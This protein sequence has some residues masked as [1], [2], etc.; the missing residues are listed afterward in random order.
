MSVFDGR[1]CHFNLL[2]ELALVS[3]YRIEPIDHV[4]LVCMC[5][6]VA[7][8]AEGIHGSERFFAASL[9][10]AIHALRLIDNEDRLRGPNQI[11]RLFAARLFAVL[12]EIVDVPFV[13]S[14]DCHHHDLNLRTGGKVPHLTELGRVV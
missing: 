6:R 10:T 8:C 3:I 14:A 4:V 2:D 13:N 9:Q 7:Q 5:C 1:R 12:I 11:N